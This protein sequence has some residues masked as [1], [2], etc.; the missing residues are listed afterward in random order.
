MSNRNGLQETTSPEGHTPLFSS[1]LE[2]PRDRSTEGD[3][4]LALPELVVELD[5]ERTDR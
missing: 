1:S 4:G 5:D 2:R 3:L